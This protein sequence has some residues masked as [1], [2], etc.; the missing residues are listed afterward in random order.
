MEELKQN[1][2]PL[3]HYI[4]NKFNKIKNALVKNSHAEKNANSSLFDEYCEVVHVFI[5]S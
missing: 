2:S 3:D 1:N 5:T 4:Q